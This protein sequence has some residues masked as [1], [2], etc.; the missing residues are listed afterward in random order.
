MSGSR[1][2]IPLHPQTDTPDTFH[3][4]TCYLITNDSSL[5]DC[6][7]DDLIGILLLSYFSFL[8]VSYFYRI[9]ECLGITVYN[10]SKYLDR[11]HRMEAPKHC[12]DEIYAVMKQCWNATP[13]D[14]PTFNRLAD[15]LNEISKNFLSSYYKGCSF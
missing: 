14:R 9:T 4:H 15:I 11:G 1:H 10:L 12:P 7:I 8:R 13:S 6:D 5:Y 3:L 2:F